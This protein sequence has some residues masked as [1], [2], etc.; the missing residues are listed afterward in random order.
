MINSDW[1]LTVVSSNK[2]QSVLRIRSEW[3]RIALIRSD[4]TPVRNF[5]QENHCR[6][7]LPWENCKNLVDSIT[8]FDS[9]AANRKFCW[10]NQISFLI[11]LAR[12]NKQFY[13]YRAIRIPRDG[14]GGGGG[15]GGGKARIHVN[16]RFLK[17]S[18][19][20]FLFQIFIPAII[21]WEN[22]KNKE[23]RPH[24]PVPISPIVLYIQLR[25]LKSPIFTIWSLKYLIFSH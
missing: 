1:F 3:P 22:V 25:F 19:T 11:H 4:W 2:I 16:T 21:L 24:R 18:L 14:G 9:Y 17:Y 13:I 10:A 8:K 5:C 15:G 7:F 20:I 23:Y 12:T 6:F